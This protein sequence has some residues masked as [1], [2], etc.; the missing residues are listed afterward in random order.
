LS[1]K[2]IDR[3]KKTHAEVEKAIEKL[4]KSMQYNYTKILKD[5]DMGKK[6]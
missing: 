1:I 5:I 6:L 2:L 3:S 4:P